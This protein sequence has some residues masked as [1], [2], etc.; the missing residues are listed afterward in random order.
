[1][2]SALNIWQVFLFHSAYIFYGGLIP[3]SCLLFIG[4]YFFGYRSNK[5]AQRQRRDEGF[6]IGDKKFNPSL[7]IFQFTNS[8]LDWAIGGILN[9]AR[10]KLWPPIHSILCD[11]LP[12]ARVEKFLGKLGAKTSI[13]DRHHRAI[14]EFDRVE[15]AFW[16]NSMRAPDFR[17]ISP[18][19][20]GRWFNGKPIENY[21]SHLIPTSAT[22]DAVRAGLLVF[23]TTFFVL[24]VAYQPSYFLGW[25]T[26]RTKSDYAKEIATQVINDPAIVPEFRKDVW[27][28][29]EAAEVKSQSQEAAVLY[30]TDVVENSKGY[31]YYFFGYIFSN[32]VLTIFF[33][34]VAVS[35][36]QVNRSYQRL[37]KLLRLPYIRDTHEDRVFAANDSEIK[38]HKIA[39]AS[40]NI[41]ATGYDKNSPLLSTYISNGAMEEK[42]MIGAKRKWEP[43]YQ[44]PLDMSQNYLAFGGSGGGK[45]LTDQTPAAVNVFDLK[46]YYYKDEKRYSELYDTRTNTLTEKAI[47]EGYLQ[48]YKKIEQPKMVISMA[49]MDFKAQVWKDLKPEANRRHLGD[50]FLII[51][52]QSGQ[53]AIDLL[54]HVNPILFESILRSMGMQ[55]GGDDGKDFWTKTALQWIR[56]FTDV[57]YIFARTRAGREF[58][59]SRLIKVMSVDFL[60][61][62]IVLDSD[63]KLFAHCVYHIFKDIQE[64]PERLSDV[65]TKERIQSIQSILT[66]WQTLAE[67]TKSGIHINMTTLMDGYNST[68]LEP[69]ITGLGEN[70]VEVGEMWKHITAFDLSVAR[71]SNTGKLILLFIKTLMYGEAAAR[72]TNFNFRAIEISEYFREQYP[73]LMILDS[74]VELL[75]PTL[76]VHDEARH[77][78]GEFI[79]TVSEIATR[80]PKIDNDELT[81]VRGTYTANLKRIAGL[82]ADDAKFEE[83]YSP[84]T[85]EDVKLAQK[86]LDISSQIRDLEPRMA[87]D[88]QGIVAIKPSMF[89]AKEGDSAEEATRKTK[90]MALYYEFE[91]CSTRIQRE[92]MFFF[93]DEFQELITVDKSGVCYSDFNFPNISRS[94]NWKFRVAT[95]TLNSL[96]IKIGRE[97]TMNFVNQM[98]SLIFLATEDESTRK[99]VTDLTN[100]ATLFTGDL[101]GKL[102]D[103]KKETQ[104]DLYR[105]YNSYISTKAAQN[106]NIILQGASLDEDA[107]YPYTYDVLTKGEPLQINYSAQNF[108][109]VFSSIFEDSKSYEFPTM[110]RHFLDE[111][112]ISEYSEKGSNHQGVQHNADQVRKD[113]HQAQKE[114]K[115]KHNQYLEKGLVRDVS[116]LSEGSYTSQGNSQAVV[117]IQRA[118]MVIKEHVLLG[119]TMYYVED[120]M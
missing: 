85:S 100:K 105:T 69:F 9:I 58:M 68:D 119:Y 27:T 10:K 38:A 65:V 1:M 22:Y 109:T 120:L 12:D 14:K 104:Y 55:L 116:L 101:R 80:V 53:F 61:R 54:K 75:D 107:I 94:T 31:N 73:E 40:A 16:W 82:H 110:Q 102:R 52:A 33:L 77:L 21:L 70:M 57:A 108:D 32:G 88:L 49:M 66:Q 115:D 50:E 37:F 42:G 39:I 48:T 92:H 19:I 96:I 56:R 112:G 47:K 78:H 62:I 60:F 45:S 71:Y 8:C 28:D 20:S 7:I 93:G 59:K 87:K 6:A 118:G 72:Q 97:E 2:N 117:F 103:G 99:L 15:N 18:V 43:I 26:D 46:N 25:M 74:S 36:V 95:Q 98:R 91:D 111:S 11:I 114:M 41:R 4:M 67:D 35:L 51:G 90:H 44:S 64:C 29:D 106:A 76:F 113:W 23:V 63:L 83:L 24:A 84:V 5:K 34:S 86:C 30:A 17:N 79:E 81:W 89:N 3:I 13:T